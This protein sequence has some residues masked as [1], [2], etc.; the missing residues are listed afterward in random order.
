M[1]LELVGAEITG[2]GGDDGIALGGAGPHAVGSYELVVERS[3]D[4][5]RLVWSV[6]NRD[7]RALRP[8]HVR[9]VLRLLDASRPL[10]VLRH[11][12]QSWSPTWV[13]THGVDRDPSTVADSIRFS[14]DVYLGDPGRVAG[15]ELRSEL[16]TVL[17]SSGGAGPHQL[18]GF[19]G[20]SRHDGTLRVRGSPDAPELVA[21]AFLGEA[22]LPR[23]AR[24]DLHPVL[25]LEGDDAPALLERWA[26]ELG[27]AQNARTGAAYQVGW[28]SWYHYFAEVT[29][30]DVRANLARAA[31]WPFEVFQV[32][33]G[34]Q[35]AIGDWLATAARF[36]SGLD[37]LAATIAGAG[38]RPGIW[39]A[40]FVVAPTARVAVDHPD[41]FARHPRRDEPRLG[42]HNPA[43]GG[44][45][46]VLDTTLPEVRAHLADV[47]GQ[48]V[49][50]GFSY[51]KV[52]FTF[53]PGLEGRFADPTATPAER[54][55]LGYEAL[56][57]GAGDDAFILACGAPLGPCVGLV[58]GMRIGADVAPSWQLDGPAFPGL[59]EV[60]P[61]TLHAYR[62]TLTRSFL[63][64]RLWCNDPDCLML[65]TEQTA[66]GSDAVRT[67]A[68]TVGM[69]GGM[70]LVSDDLALLDRPARALLDEVLALGRESDAAARAGHPARCEDL[71]DAP[72]PTRLTVS[73][74]RLV[75]DPAAPV[76]RL[77]HPSGTT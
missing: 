31:D 3:D 29:E 46:W 40:P 62:N 44:D 35:R 73:G 51:L 43:W 63:H 71:M 4:G 68:M 37:E 30:Q 26:A 70:A 22:E 38:F 57:R 17:G 59:P 50:A 39:L 53:A 69:S 12:Y 2:E 45:T 11:G 7:D 20:G 21:E 58:D 15:D 54:V 10:R 19:L 16:V 24:R 36:P 49:D 65:R 47:A 23:H 52:D 9:L 72:T 42:W 76:S 28:C 1:R 60:S 77:E 8:R 18:V 27:A 25:L 64:R 75:T 41:W 67:W 61:A 6:A 48:L 13:G 5:R 32:D 33:D 34:Y 66:M 14:R 56:R 74:R 55:R